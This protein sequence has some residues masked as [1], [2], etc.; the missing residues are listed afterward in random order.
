MK[1]DA[2]NHVKPIKKPSYNNIPKHPILKSNVDFFKA[3]AEESPNMIFLNFKGKVIYANKKCE[4]IMGYTRK[5]FYSKDFS[6]FDLMTPESIEKTKMALNIHAQGKEVTPYEYSLQTKTGRRIEAI[7]TT[8]LIRIGNEPVILGIVT[9]I[10]HQK[11]IELALL[12]SEQNYRTILDSFADPIHVVDNKLNIIFANNAL[13]DFNSSLGLKPEITGK[14]VFQ[15]YPFLSKN[16]IRKEYEKVFKTAETL[17]TEDNTTIGKQELHTET[18]KIPVIINGKTV[19]LLTTIR[20]ITK[21]KTSEKELIT[22]NE[23]LKKSNKKLEQLLIMDSHTGLYNHRYLDKSINAEFLRAKHESKPLSIIFID[24]DYFKSINDLYGHQFGD[25]ILR[26]FAQKLMKFVHREDTIIRYGGEEFI[27]LCPNTESAAV[28]TLAQKIRNSINFAHFGFKKRLV[29]LRLSIAVT[30]FPDDHASSALEMIE[31]A[32]R[33]L[34]KAKEQG[35]NRVFSLSDLK[36]G[37]YENVKSKKKEESKIEVT[38]LKE[39]MER[40]HRRANQ[41]LIE[42]V[43]AFAK[44]IE[45]KDHY[46]GEHVER[47]VHFATEIAKQLEMSKEDIMHIRQAAILHDLGKVGISERILL[48][49]NKLTGKEFEEI[50]EHP[51]I[52]ADILRPIHMLHDILPYIMHHHERWDGKGYPQGLK[53]DNIPMG[54]RVI[55]VA[56][57][58]QAL[59]SNRPYRK[60]YRKAKA[61]KIISEGAGTKFDPKI[62]SAFLKVVHKL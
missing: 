47:T 44:T 53:G 61:V 8:K 18:R 48:K 54:A 10:S 60:A 14:S 20:N 16:K 42:A 46:T 26:Q 33:I 24:L 29:K 28:K 39:K 50:M 31:C 13:K 5:E 62:V 45:L 30:S 22:L 25:T 37:K 59:I 4:E 36:A 34:N 32:D 23:A 55:C 35:G 27:I 6:F 56:D 1:P 52:G 17:I 58:Y 21:N 19:R 7:I 38:Y 57:T 43:F 11:K 40:L 49:P 15:A 2:A 3:L 9:D 51:L 12:T 41:S